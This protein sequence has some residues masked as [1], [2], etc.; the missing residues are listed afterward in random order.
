M[1]TTLIRVGRTY[2]DGSEADYEAV[3]ALQAQYKVVP[4]S[5]WGKPY[6]YKAPPV[7]PEAWFQHDG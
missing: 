7:D 4:L 2:A 6:T 1:K 5:E 3:N